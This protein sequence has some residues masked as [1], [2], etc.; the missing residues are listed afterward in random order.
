M[1]KCSGGGKAELFVV[2]MSAVCS[3]RCIALLPAQNWREG[4]TRNK[5]INSFSLFLNCWEPSVFEHYLIDYLILLDWRKKSIS[6]KQSFSNSPTRDILSLHI[7][8]YPA[9]G[10]S[11]ECTP[12][13]IHSCNVLQGK[14]CYVG[15]N[16]SKLQW[17]NADIYSWPH[18]F[19]SEETVSNDSF[20][21][22]C[23]QNS[24]KLS[25]IVFVWKIYRIC[26]KIVW[27]PTTW[28]RTA[29]SFLK[30]MKCHWID[31]CTTTGLSA[32]PLS[33]Q[34]CGPGGL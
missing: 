29:V 21:Q 4:G 11:D 14:K 1:Q 25:G 22:Q 8:V 7:V 26:A 2:W 9:V 20:E 12:N 15:V 27:P 23:F 34:F 13:V 5:A 3:R 19:E 31:E 6:K 28:S 17:Q 24:W 33:Q 30:Q 32:T 18:C 16:H 10:S